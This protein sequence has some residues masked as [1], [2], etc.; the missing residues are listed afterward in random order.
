MSETFLA[1]RDVARLIGVTKG[2]AAS[3]K[4][5]GMLPAPDAV[6]GLDDRSVAGWRKETIIK[7]NEERPGKGNHGQ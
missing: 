6:I 1:L 7:W 4:A 3:Y 2:T 5:K